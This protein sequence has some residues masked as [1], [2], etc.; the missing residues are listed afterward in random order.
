MIVRALGD[1]DTG[2]SLQELIAVITRPNATVG[3]QQ[4]AVSILSRKDVSSLQKELKAAVQDLRIPVDPDSPLAEI[5]EQLAGMIQTQ[6]PKMAPT[7]TPGQPIP[8]S[9][10]QLSDTSLDDELSRMIPHYRELSSEVR[11][12]LRTALFFNHTITGSEAANAIDLSPLIDMQYKAMELLFRESFEDAVTQ[13]LHRGGIQRKLDVIGYA[14]P[15]PQAMDEFENYIANLPMVREI[16]FFSKFKLRKMLRA[17]CQFQPG[18]RF[19]LDGLKAFGLFFL[20]FGRNQCQF[21]LG[22]MFHI[23]AKDD[24]ELAEFCKELHVFQD[25]RNR[26]AHEGFHP[27]ASNDI[28][29][30]WRTTALIVQWAFRIRSVLNASKAVVHKRV[31]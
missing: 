15:I 6:A 26:A 19:T 12:A 2:R 22:N 21:G 24:L 18:R 3:I 4:D 13:S 20:C 9:A 5:R 14:R 27:S 28:Q 17:I 16:P 25:F 31:S 23:G 10:V 30:I 1:I 7:S 8:M 11:R 29:G